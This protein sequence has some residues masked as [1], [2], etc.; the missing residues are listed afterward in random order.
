MI[1]DILREI[2]NVERRIRSFF[3]HTYYPVVQ[4]GF[5]PPI[6]IYENENEYILLV[7]L[8]GVKPENLNL[9]IDKNNVLHIYGVKEYPL[10]PAQSYCHS[11]EIDFGRF[12]RFIRLGTPVE[13]SCELENH[14]GIFKIVLRKKKPKERIIEIK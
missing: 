8:P 4:E 6:D 9:A 10:D 1:K 14:N 12:E 2:E 11:I 13:D 5:S 7:E 3:E